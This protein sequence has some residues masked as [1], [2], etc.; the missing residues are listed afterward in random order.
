MLGLLESRLG[1]EVSGQ[2]GNVLPVPSTENTDALVADLAALR[3]RATLVE[4]TADN[5]QQG[6]QAPRGD[7]TPRR[8]GANRPAVLPALRSDGG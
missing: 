2:V 1:D 5:W 7:W 3:G 4:S 8:M 6:G